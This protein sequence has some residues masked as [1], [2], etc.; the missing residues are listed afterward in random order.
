[1]PATIA[2]FKQA[3]DAELAH[4]IRAVDRPWATW[5][6]VFAA[7][8]AL[9]IAVTIGWQSASQYG[10]ASNTWADSDWDSSWL[11]DTNHDAVVLTDIET[12][13]SAL[14]KWSSDDSW[15]ANGS[16]FYETVN[17]ALE[18]TPNSNNPGDKGASAAPPQSAEKSEEA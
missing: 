5:Q 1:L 14:E 11:S 12:N 4:G 7:A 18:E 9:A 8:A 16:K 2:R 15:E 13:L 17:D 10:A 6:G 3:I